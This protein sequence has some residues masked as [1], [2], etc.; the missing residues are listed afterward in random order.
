MVPQS[1]YYQRG[2]SYL[3]EE[4]KK[5]YVEDHNHS[6]FPFPVV[7]GLT[8]DFDDPP[9]LEPTHFYHDVREERLYSDGM[10]G[11]RQGGCCTGG[12]SQTAFEDCF[13]KNCKTEPR[14]GVYDHDFVKMLAPA[15]GKKKLKYH[16]VVRALLFWWEKFKKLSE[17]QQSFLS[18]ESFLFAVMC[19]DRRKFTTTR[20]R[21]CCWPTKIERLGTEDC[22][23][24]PCRCDMSPKPDFDLLDWLRDD[25]LNPY[26]IPETL[27]ERIYHMKHHVQEFNPYKVALFDV[28]EEDGTLKACKFNDVLLK[29]YK[30]VKAA[31]QQEKNVFDSLYL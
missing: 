8:K 6:L 4:L 21:K 16:Y 18:F 15:V 27:K 11:G 14:H 12:V 31:N 7:R 13:G 23:N 29:L 5:D 22:F 10:D 3:R 2:T 28:T 1:F 9:K 26:Y 30:N 17:L 20:C 19:L 24:C 25:P